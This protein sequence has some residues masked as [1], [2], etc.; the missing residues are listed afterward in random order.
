LGI[1]FS[2]DGRTL[3]GG[4]QDGQVWVWDQRTN[5]PLH[6]FTI[7]EPPP[8]PDELTASGRRR[9]PGLAFSPDGKTLAVGAAD[10]QIRLLDSKGE[11]LKTFSTFTSPVER[12][13]FS[14]DGKLLL[15]WDIDAVLRVW[16][17]ETGAVTHTFTGY[18]SRF[19]GLQFQSDGTLAAWGGSSFWKMDPTTGSVLHITNIGNGSIFAAS[20][21]GRHLAVYHSSN[22][23]LWDA[24][25]G[26]LLQTL[27]GEPYEWEIMRQ[28][29]EGF[30][31]AQFSPDDRWLAAV[32][33]GGLWIWRREDGRLVQQVELQVPELATAMAFSPDGR[34]SAVN[35]QAYYNLSV[36]DTM[37]GELLRQFGGS[38]NNQEIYVGKVAFSP[39]GRWL[40][41]TSLVGGTHPISIWNL[42]NG[43]RVITLSAGDAVPASL[44][45]SPDGRLLAVG[46]DAG[47]VGL[48]TTTDFTQATTIEAHTGGVLY[49]AFSVDG[50]WLASANEDGTISVWGTDSR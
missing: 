9:L 24:V 36:L 32:G 8:Y 1:A 33:S 39:N 43:Q 42:G 48:W 19:S 2:P 23:G 11:V 15:A 28:V 12:L 16:D 35:S 50:R 25:T 41:T 14:R 6:T 30:N 47:Q 49:L 40:A 10:G 20:H 44:A 45:F 18:A 31:S 3:A 21:D 29:Y 4:T 34:L 13:A 37:S 38:G 46:T 5:E 27:E 7:F 26:T 22:I 17:L